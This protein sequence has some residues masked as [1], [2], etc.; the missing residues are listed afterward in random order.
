MTY[1]SRACQKNSKRGPRNI[2]K[3]AEE[4]RTSQ[5]HYDRA[6]VLAEFIYRKPLGER[7]GAMK[8]IID[9]ARSG[10]DGSLRRILTDPKLLNAE[11]QNIRLF[12][13]RNPNGYHTI[14]QAAHAYCRRCW[15]AGV[16]QVV[17]CRVDEPGE[18]VP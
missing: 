3:N 14:A 7:L 11:P 2:M 8:A 13:R 17:Y 9:H 1:C 5:V 18:A 10:Q 12:Y 15:G 4:K 16:R 6:L